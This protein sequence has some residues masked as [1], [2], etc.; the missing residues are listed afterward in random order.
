MA[1][2]AEKRT[3]KSTRT[4]AAFGGSTLAPQLIAHYL[5][6]TGLRHERA[7]RE[8]Q[9]DG[10]GWKRRAP[11]EK[12]DRGSDE[13]SAD[14]DL[15]EGSD[16][17]MY[18]A[19]SF[20]QGHARGPILE[21]VS[22][23][24]A[25]IP[26]QFGSL[27]ALGRCSRA[28]H[29][30]VQPFIVAARFSLVVGAVPPRQHFSQQSMG[31]DVVLAAVEIENVQQFSLLN[32]QEELQ[33]LAELVGQIPDVLVT[34]LLRVA[35]GPHQ[36][37]STRDF[38]I[39][40]CKISRAMESN[41][42]AK[43]PR[44]YMRIVTAV[45]IFHAQPAWF[46]PSALNHAAFNLMNQNVKMSGGHLAN[47]CHF[48]WVGA[49]GDAPEKIFHVSL[50]VRVCIFFHGSF[51]AARRL[52]CPWYRRFF[53]RDLVGNV[54][55]SA[56]SWSY[57]QMPPEDLV[58]IYNRTL[59]WFSV[60]VDR[61]GL[62]L[63]VGTAAQRFTLD[64]SFVCRTDVPRLFVSKTQ[65]CS[66]ER[67][68]AL[69]FSRDELP[70]LHTCNSC[71]YVVKQGLGKKDKNEKRPGFCQFPGSPGHLMKEH[72]SVSS[73]LEGLVKACIDTSGLSRQKGNDLRARALVSLQQSI[74]KSVL[75]AKFVSMPTLPTDRA[76]RSSSSSDAHSRSAIL[77]VLQSQLPGPRFE[78]LPSWLIGES[79]EHE[80]SEWTDA[81]SRSAITEGLRAQL[82][83]E[84]FD[85]V[86]QWI[87]GGQ[88]SPMQ[89][90]QW[91]YMVREKP[92]YH[93]VLM[94]QNGDQMS[95]SDLRLIAG[96]LRPYADVEG[97]SS[98]ARVFA[99]YSGNL[100]K[101]LALAKPAELTLLVCA[102]LRV[103]CPPIIAT[104]AELPGAFRQLAQQLE[105]KVVG[106]AETVP[107]ERLFTA[108]RSLDASLKC[109][110]FPATRAEVN[111][112]MVQAA[113]FRVDRLPLERNLER[114]ALREA[115]IEDM[116]IWQKVDDDGFC[117]D[118]HLLYPSNHTRLCEAW[119]LI[120]PEQEHLTCAKQ[121]ERVV[122]E[123]NQALR[124][125]LGTG[126]RSRRAGGDVQEAIKLAQTAHIAAMQR[127]R[128]EKGHRGSRSY[129]EVMGDVPAHLDQAYYYL[130]GN[131]RNELVKK[132]VH[133]GM[134]TYSAKTWKHTGLPAPGTW[135]LDWYRAVFYHRICVETGND[136]H[137]TYVRISRRSSIDR[138]K[139]M[140][141]LMGA[142]SGR[143]IV[144]MDDIDS[145]IDA[146][147][148]GEPL[149]DPQF[150]FEVLGDSGTVS[151]S[152]LRPLVSR[153]EK[154]LTT[155]L[156]Q[157]QC[158]IADAVGGEFTV[159]DTFSRT[160]S[161]ESRR[162]RKHASMRGIL[163]TVNSHRDNVWAVV[164]WYEDAPDTKMDLRFYRS[165]FTLKQEAE[166]YYAAG[167]QAAISYGFDVNDAEH[168]RCKTILPRNLLP[169]RVGCTTVQEL[170]DV[171]VEYF[172]GNVTTD[173]DSEWDA[174]ALLG[175]PSVTRWEL[176]AAG[177][178]VYVG[179]AGSHR[180]SCNL[181]DSN[182][183]ATLRVPTPD[184][185][186]LQALNMRAREGEWHRLAYEG[187]EEEDQLFDIRGEE[188][189]GDIATNLM[190][191]SIVSGENGGVA[192]LFQDYQDVS[193]N[194]LEFVI[195]EIE[196][197]MGFEGTLNT[198]IACGH[199]GG[200]LASQFGVF[201]IWSLA[202]TRAGVIARLRV[203]QP[204]PSTQL[205]DTA[206]SAAEQGM[207]RKGVGQGGRAAAADTSRE[208][209][210]DPASAKRLG[211][212]LE[213]PKKRPMRL[214]SLSG[215]SDAKS[216]APLAP[217]SEA[218]FCNQV[219]LAVAGDY[220]E[221]D[222]PPPDLYVK[223]KC[224][225]A[226]A[227]ASVTGRHAKVGEV[228]RTVTAG[229]ICDRPRR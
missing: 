64:N 161:D 70:E 194:V 112:F 67:A 159:L 130:K 76:T 195:Q 204:T 137:W 72:V 34:D 4:S 163:V 181:A 90:S 100:A 31:G 162:K 58:K 88:Q 214:L 19:G 121:V 212:E 54:K 2:M 157:Y 115:G 119:K 217:L 83:E 224:L 39:R 91:P 155:W 12:E 27:Q 210:R 33:A 113:L 184:S 36:L 61:G 160:A 81:E 109:E 170:Y 29:K 6:T 43:L 18:S 101:V 154:N 226:M 62:V 85:R 69:A 148:R 1:Q 8:W 30:L 111:M 228:V 176:M 73:M 118:N 24:S 220:D 35:N 87:V 53:E 136:K 180:W 9:Q 25:V 103:Q 74:G 104:V 182:M 23:I 106:R 48:Q 218:D 141:C 174:S 215:G 172:N 183:D 15:H 196:S 177:G 57:T 188:V 10:E 110:D 152:L 75:A 206:A 133:S 187:E 97:T 52:S 225:Q 122:R 98:C 202:V 186:C 191:A 47:S 125:T 56:D 123:V 79:A 107:A 13:G 165:P 171:A 201:G 211:G 156:E 166:A 129:D 7:D 168:D 95:R 28:F 169:L 63:G 126:N 40:I 71:V 222:T 132:R 198:N 227:L 197:Q 5:L 65:R 138:R 150:L 92:P 144:T 175:R 229:W 11:Q 41:Q 209:E 213:S 66:L 20:S 193:A 223:G 164:L 120:K 158:S 117:V 114:N 93:A 21:A 96:V 78:Q 207:L 38:K 94:C 60:A 145:A 147:R 105:P 146:D 185:E 128:S 108:L 42:W 17:D 208:A 68:I 86:P 80:P 127:F 149:L 26:P 200:S 89:S 178:F 173:G 32:C 219:A 45:K 16:G 143:V 59:T 221:G 131:I 192:W 44:G 3:Q 14:E 199:N 139:A 99:K 49:V 82:P 50:V 142:S 153:V 205:K 135:H 190:L 140:H 51:I 216:Q 124:R 77:R 84:V 151:A 203:K 134:Q 167:E 37:S 189:F 102:A 116:S 22:S 55:R 46:E 179:G